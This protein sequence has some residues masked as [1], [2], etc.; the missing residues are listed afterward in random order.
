[1]NRGEG[2]GISIDDD[3]IDAYLQQ[4]SEM[5]DKTRG[6]YGKFYIERTDGK[7]EP[8]QKHH[9]CDYFVLDLTHDPFAWMALAAYSRACEKEYPLL[10][11]DL[12]EKIRAALRAAEAANATEPGAGEAKP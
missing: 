4:E 11:A 1:M 9:N 8:G 7:S 6:L 12:D 5:G 10:S 3:D 2:Y